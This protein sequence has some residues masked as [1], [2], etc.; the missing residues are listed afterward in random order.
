MTNFVEKIRQNF[1]VTKFKKE[2][3]KPWQQ[4]IEMSQS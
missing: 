4:W 1:N 3:R 2:K